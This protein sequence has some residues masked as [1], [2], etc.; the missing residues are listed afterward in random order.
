MAGKL[1]CL[2]YIEKIVVEVEIRCKKWAGN[3]CLLSRCSL[4]EREQ[5]GDGEAVVVVA[6]AQA[7]KRR[8]KQVF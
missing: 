2:L 6:F 1:M 4:G 7:T 3:S 8:A 5:V